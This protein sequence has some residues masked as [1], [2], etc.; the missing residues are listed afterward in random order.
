M[1]GSQHAESFCCNVVATGG[2]QHP[3]EKK[4]FVDCSILNKTSSVIVD[5]VINIENN[6]Q[7]K[8]KC[9]QEEIDMN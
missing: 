4:H 1:S 3:F 7:I 8:E 5:S 6:S 9:F 2:V